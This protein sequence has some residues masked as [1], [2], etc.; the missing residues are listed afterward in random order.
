MGEFDALKPPMHQVA[1]SHEDADALT[2]LGMLLDRIRHMLHGANVALCTPVRPVARF[3][4][5]LALVTPASSL[6]C[7]THSSL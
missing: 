7:Q 1:A 3:W 4:H 5:K 6:H 2:E